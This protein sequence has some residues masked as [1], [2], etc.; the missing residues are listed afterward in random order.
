MSKTIWACTTFIFASMVYGKILK[1]IKPN[2]FLSCFN[3]ITF[4][5]N[6]YFYFV[7]P[8]KKL[9]INVVDDYF[10][11]FPGGGGLIYTQ[12]SSLTGV[13]LWS[14]LLEKAYARH[15]GSYNLLTPGRFSFLFFSFLF[16]LSFFLILF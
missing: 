2:I 6:L 10:P 12:V 16:S 11:C 7:K 14:A 9:I 1:V 4:I 8:E 15:R 13:Q 3:F 5:P